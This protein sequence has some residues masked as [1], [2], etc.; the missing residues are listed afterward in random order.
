[1]GKIKESKHINAN[2]TIYDAVNRMVEAYYPR[3]FNATTDA[4]AKMELSSFAVSLTDYICK[5]ID[6][7]CKKTMQESSNK[8]E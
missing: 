8:S 3:I 6:D 7:V 1:M 4:K 2:S 5:Q